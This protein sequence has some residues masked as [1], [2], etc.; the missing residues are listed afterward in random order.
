MFRRVRVFFLIIILRAYNVCVSNPYV[1]WVLSTYAHHCLL[2]LT[3]KNYFTFLECSERILI[4][5]MST[6]GK[7]RLS[8]TL[9]ILWH[10]KFRMWRIIILFINILRWRFYIHIYF[11]YTYIMLLLCDIF[12]FYITFLKRSIRN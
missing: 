10:Y 4:N 8:Q 9:R 3:S 1:L 7:S 5:I 12:E 6:N 11:L 2:C